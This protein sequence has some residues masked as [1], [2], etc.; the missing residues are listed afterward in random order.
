MQ[1]LAG[2][3]EGSGFGVVSGKGASAFWS[4]SSMIFTFAIKNKKGGDWD[5]R[6]RKREFKVE[7]VLPNLLALFSQTLKAAVRNN[8]FPNLPGTCPILQVLS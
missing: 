6:G 2:S 7:T 3:G 8:L 4:I 5:G 1:T